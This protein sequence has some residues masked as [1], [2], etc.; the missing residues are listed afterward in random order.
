MQFDHNY[1]MNQALLLAKSVKSE[2]PVGAIIVCNNQIISQAVNKM[3]ELNDP[4][5]HAEMLVIKDA[6]KKINNWRLD[7][8]ILYVTLEPCS[9]CA[10]AIINSRVKKLV[11]G[12]YDLSCGA[13]GSVINIFNEFGKEKN[14]HVIGGICEEESS[15]LL[16]DFFSKQRIKA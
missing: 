13:C 4:T 8:T 12:A 6:A 15:R 10:G 7:S 14:I 3:E 1:W 5:A 2:V 9:M 16:K 11:F